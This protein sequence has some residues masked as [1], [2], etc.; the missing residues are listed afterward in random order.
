MSL[1]VLHDEDELLKEGI[2]EAA[3]RELSDYGAT[4]DDDSSKVHLPSSSKRRAHLP[5]LWREGGPIKESLPRHFDVDYGRVL[6]IY[7]CDTQL[8]RAA[9]TVTRSFVFY[10]PHLYIPSPP[11]PR[12]LD[13]LLTIRDSLTAQQIAV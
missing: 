12:C 4:K 9:L 8:N 1:E 3:G 13:G 5:S 11:S 6:G 10:L 7:V 2:S